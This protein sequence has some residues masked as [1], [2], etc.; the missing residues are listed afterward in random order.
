M[1]L[2]K[3]KTDSITDDAITAAK[4]DDDGTGFT[5]GDLA[6]TGAV[7]FSSTAS[8]KMPSGTTLQRGTS[9]TGALRFNSQTSEFEGY[10]GTEWGT[11]G[12]GGLTDADEDTYITAEATADS[13][14][15]DFWTAGTQ[16]MKIDQAGVVTVGVNDVGYDVQFFG[17]T[18]G[19]YMLWDEDQNKLVVS[20]DITVTGTVAGVTAT[21]VGL[22]NVDNTTDA[23][24]P[25]STATQTAL[26]LKAPLAA[27]A[28]TGTATG[29]NLTLS[30]DLTV[31]GTT[32]TLDTTLENVDKLEVG[33]NSTDYGAKINQ[34]GTGD[35]LQLQDG[36]TTVFVVEDGGNVGIGTTS[37]SIKLDFG[38][39]GDTTLKQIIGLRT[40]SNSRIGIGTAN[41]GMSQAYYVPS[42]IT[43]TEGFVWGTI[44]SGDGSTFAEKMRLTREGNLGIGVTAGQASAAQLHI[45]GTGTGAGDTAV[46][47]LSRD[48]ADQSFTSGD[49]MGRLVWRYGPST[50]SAAIR[51]EVS[52]GWSGGDHPTKLVFS[53]TADGSGTLTDRMTINSSGYVTK[54]NQPAFMAYHDP[55]DVNYT[56]T[57]NVDNTHFNTGNHYN[58]SNSTFTAPIAGKYL[59]TIQMNANWNTAVPRAYW[60]INNGNVGNGIHLRGS[61]SSHDGLEM[62]SYTVILNLSASDAVRIYINVDRFD[63]FGAN[64][65][66]GCL[67]H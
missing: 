60:Q 4:I 27:P 55:G 30:G 53:T 7:D 43:S 50:D 36:G 61:D 28:F 3:I 37:P 56:S 11:I 17:A 32:T 42:D 57:I 22:G 6:V 40:N 49:I 34:A 44:A 2:K 52:A 16:R 41:S 47:A 38:L 45:E 8:I 14:D 54:P 67:L 59:F 64:S 9:T 46:L 51:G 66:S 65:F 33:A 26:N 5:F 58:T 63:M 13:D 1:P 21:H 25:V 15:L 10:N 23:N 19:K 31:N 48:W 35:I 24:K 29:V 62:R 20:G 18:T 39:P 12:G